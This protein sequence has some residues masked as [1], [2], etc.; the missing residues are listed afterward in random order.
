[1]DRPDPQQMSEHI[2]QAKEQEKLYAEGKIRFPPRVS[3]AQWQALLDSYLLL[4]KTEAERQ[5]RELKRKALRDLKKQEE[6]KD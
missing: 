3:S 2:V 1:M 4:E 6:K 5:A